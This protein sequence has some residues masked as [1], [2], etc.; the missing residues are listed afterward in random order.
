MSSERLPSLNA[1]RAFEAVGRLGSVRAAGDELGVSHTVIS[2]HVRHLQES[3]GLVL[4]AQQG[5][6]LALTETGRRYHRDVGN[7]FN[8]LKRATRAARDRRPPKLTLWCA[9][10]IVSRRLL[11]HLPE[12]TAPPRGWDVDLQ[13]TLAMPNLVDGEADAA[14]LYGD[15]VEVDPRLKVEELVRPRVFPVASP[16]FLAR[17]RMPATLDELAA[18]TLLHEESTA[19]WQQWLA[20]AGYDGKLVLGG[21]RLWHAQLALDAARLGQGIAIANE[22]LIADELAS[23]TL[24][25]IMATHVVIG[26]YRLTAL[27]ERWDEPAITVLRD[28]LR[29]ALKPA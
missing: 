17:H 25:E 15:D 18:S 16:S 4:L 22:V 8:I 28:W 14:V 2:R 5:R 26:A 10:G 11:A 24:V 20:L 23:G 1:L 29:E 3:L 27:R 9:P 19:Q 7:A 12:L 6:N 21:Q 13:P